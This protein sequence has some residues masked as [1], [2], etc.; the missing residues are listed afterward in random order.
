MKEQKK[1]FHA[2]HV[3]YIPGV[4]IDFNK[5]QITIDINQKKQE[6]ELPPDKFILFIFRRINKT[7]NH[8][9]IIRAIRNYKDNYAS[10]PFH[11]IICGQG[12]LEGYLKDLA[13]SLVFPSILP[14]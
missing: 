8:E 12:V 10:V 11:Y 6:L 4:G 13:D 5:E 7:Q 3:S 14:F 9:T 2:K 1:H